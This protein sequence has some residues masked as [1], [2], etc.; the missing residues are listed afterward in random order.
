MGMTATEKIIARACGVASVKPGEVVHPNPDLVFLHDGQV[1]NSKKMLDELGIDR[2]RNR[3]KVVFVTDHEVIYTTARAAQ[4]GVNIRKAARTWS[5]RNFYDVGQGGHG[6]VFPIETGMVLP[7]MFIFANDMHVTNFGALGA[8]G[9]RAGA[10]VT[11][12]LAMGTLW[13]LV[14]RTV[15]LTLEGKLRAGVF[16]RDAGFKVSKHLANRDFGVDITYRVLELAGPGLDDL[17]LDQRVALCSTPT[18]INA[19]NVFIP[20]SKAVLDRIAAVSGKVL[21]PVYSDADAVFEAD[22]SFDLST[23]EPQ[24]ALPGA[25]ENAVDVSSVAGKPVDHA[26]I[27]SCGS[28]MYE[29]MALAARVLRGR[30]VAAGT[31]L[32]VVPGSVRTAKRLADEGLMSLFQEAGA[33]MLQSGCGPCAGG[34][35]GLL[36][37]GE[38]SI[39]T[40]ATNG[41]GRMGAKDAECYLGSPATVAVSAVAG[42]IADPR[43]LSY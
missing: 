32:F 3:D 13:T 2:V 31:R 14:P 33:I 17:G 41:A 11:S 36:H 15:R 27:G 10:E 25:P 29:D 30:K 22:I 42:K 26:Y 21:A 12:V 40:A 4:R 34:T 19:I 39:S 20:P 43:S 24:V 6:H 1:E 38:V 28:S 16:G 7:G 23:L 18:E 35:L 37:S 9:L 5:I 8:F